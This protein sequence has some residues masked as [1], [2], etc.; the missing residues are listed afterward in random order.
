MMQTVLTVLTLCAR[1]KLVN[2]ILINHLNINDCI[3]YWIN[4]GH[5]RNM[6]IFILLR[7]ALTMVLVI[8]RTTCRCKAPKITESSY[9]RAFAAHRSFIFWASENRTFNSE[10]ITY[11][12][13]FHDL[14]RNSENIIPK[15][16][17]K[18]LENAKNRIVST[19]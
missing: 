10:Q 2:D 8:A 12:F 11:R 6:F 18:S 4:N 16:W 14:S 9:G 7:T 13:S 17:Q 15:T 3:I 5:I 1:N 19:V